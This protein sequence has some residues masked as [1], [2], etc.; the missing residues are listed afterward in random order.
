[1]FKI[2]KV[3]LI[4]LAPEDCFKK[5]TEED[6]M[7]PDTLPIGHAVDGDESKTPGCRLK[8]DAC[9]LLHRYFEDLQGEAWS[10]SKY[11]IQ[12][13]N[14]TKYAIRQLNNICLTCICFWEYCCKNFGK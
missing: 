6:F 3:L 7:Y 5:F 10:L 8:H 4:L 9:N 11:Y 2:F 12:A 13:D 1:M 14:K